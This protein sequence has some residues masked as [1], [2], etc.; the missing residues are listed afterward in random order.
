MWVCGCTSAGHCS[1]IRSCS[2][3]FWFPH[4]NHQLYLLSTDA[5]THHTHTHTHS[6]SHIVFNC[7]GAFCESHNT[8]CLF[9][10][11]GWNEGE[12]ICCQ[13]EGKGNLNRCFSANSIFLLLFIFFCSL[14]F[15]HCVFPTTGIKRMMES[16]KNKCPSVAMETSSVIQSNFAKVVEKPV[17]FLTKVKFYFSLLRTIMIQRVN[18]KLNDALHFSHYFSMKLPLNF[19]IL[20]ITFMLVC[21]ATC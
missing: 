16:G 20:S 13:C 12:N 7:R 3:P 8:S 1:Q 14:P 17:A 19:M 11:H 5:H 2:A 6:H 18:I 21:V 10:H 9:L 15:V 4:W